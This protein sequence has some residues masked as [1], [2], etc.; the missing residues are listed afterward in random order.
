MFIRD[1]KCIDSIK[2]SIPDFKEKFEEILKKSLKKTELE[3]RERFR[4]NKPSSNSIQLLKDMATNETEVRVLAEQPLHECFKGFVARMKRSDLG[5][6]D[7]NGKIIFDVSKHEASA[8]KPAK[9]VL[10]RFNDDVAYFANDANSQL[11]L[12]LSDMHDGIIDKFFRKDAGAA[13]TLNKDARDKL[14]QLKNTLDTILSRDS[15]M[16]QN[17]VPMM[18]TAANWV[19]IEPGDSNELKVQKI[20]FKLGRVSGHRAFV[21]IEFLFGSLLSSNGDEDLLRLNPFLTGPTVDL[22]FALIAA[23]MLRANRLGLANRCM[24]T[25]ISLQAMLDKVLKIP[26]EE[27]ME[28][29]ETAAPKL[30]Q[31]S[32]ELAKSIAMGRY[33]MNPAVGGGGGNANT[34]GTGAKAANLIKSCYEFDPRYLV[35]EFIWNIQ[36][37][38]KQVKVINYFRASL[39]DGVSKVKQMI[40]GAGKTS[41]VAPLLALIV[42]D[43]KSLVLSVVPKALV[44]MSRTR[45]RE[46][47]AVIMVKRIYTLEFDRSTV[48]KPSMRRSLENAAAN[49]GVVV[50]TPSKGCC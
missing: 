29:R 5:L 25:L 31:L 50:A 14:R 45:M 24:G 28:A 39:A 20:K 6:D 13:R 42:A 30:I 22:L 44:E 47:F 34:A 35:F 43:G 48:V 36:L 1:N 33:F 3:A 2:G 23:C 12:K 21:W 15:N 27:R 16:I 18:E 41:V 32:E 8:S 40:M 37:R 26:L 10:K 9:A 17:I 49:R 7:I 19:S 11:Q 46:T 38:K 4:Q